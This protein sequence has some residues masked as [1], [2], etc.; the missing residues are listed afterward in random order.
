MDTGYPGF[1]SMENIRY[2][3]V[4]VIVRMKIEFDLRVRIEHFFAK[5]ID[6]VGIKYSKGIR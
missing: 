4:V 6:L 2:G 1:D 5:I 3:Q